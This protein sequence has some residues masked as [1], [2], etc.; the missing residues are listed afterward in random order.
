M[1]PKRKKKQDEDNDPPDKKCIF[2]QKVFSEKSKATN[3]MQRKVCRESRGLAK[4]DT[5]SSLKCSVCDAGPY[6]RERDLT[7]HVR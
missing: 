3:H 5:S 4:E 6:S 7:R 1:P 2:C